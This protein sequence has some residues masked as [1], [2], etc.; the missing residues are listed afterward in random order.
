MVITYYGIS[1]FKI[2]SGDTIL[3]FDIPSKKALVKPPRFHSDIVVQSHDHDGHNGG[4]DQQDTFLTDGPG[5]YEIKGM[6]IHG[7]K[8][9][10]DSFFG[11]KRGLNT[12]YVCRV[13]NINLCFFGDFGEKELRPELKEEMGNIDILFVPIGGDSVLEPEAARNIINQIE[14]AIAIPMHYDRGKRNA[15]KEFLAEMGQRDVKP[16]E[17]FSIKKKDINENGTQVV[18]LSVV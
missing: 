17:K 2:Q 15:L 8:S 18:V 9:F 5:E 13:E 3:A 6:R 7:L 12:V 1:C 14:P 11:K 10:H 4:G 16:V